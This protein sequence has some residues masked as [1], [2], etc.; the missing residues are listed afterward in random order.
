MYG[1]FDTSFVIVWV[2]VGACNYGHRNHVHRDSICVHHN[3]S[4]L[5]NYLT[6]SGM[7]MFHTCM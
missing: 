6:Y 3:A 4:G 1:R 5:L 7:M 2:H